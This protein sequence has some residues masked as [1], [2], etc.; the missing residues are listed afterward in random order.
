MTSDAQSCFTDDSQRI[1]PGISLHDELELMV[2]A[3]LT[4]YQALQTATVNAARALGE[5]DRVGRIAAGYRADLILVE[6]DPLADIGVLREPVAIV[7]NG[8]LIDIAGR[9]ALIEASTQTDYDRSAANVLEALA[10]QG[11]QRTGQ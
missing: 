3:G 11:A 8:R 6:S 2:E 7:F 4:P 5:E 1:I 10:V 9:A